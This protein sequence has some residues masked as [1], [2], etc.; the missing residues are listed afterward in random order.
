MMT[1]I[2]IASYSQDKT[3]EL[4]QESDETFY[5]YDLGENGIL[6]SIPKIYEHNSVV[7][8]YQVKSQKIMKYSNQLEKEW[9]VNV[10]NPKGTD[11]SNLTYSKEG[12]NV[13]IENM[14]FSQYSESVYQL[15]N[16]KD[17]EIKNKKEFD[18]N[19][20]EKIRKNLM[21]SFCDNENFYML[22]SLN[23]KQYEKSKIDEKLVLTIFKGESMIMEKHVLNLPKIEN[24]ENTT[25][26]DYLDHHDGEIYLQSKEIFSDVIKYTIL[27]INSNGEILNTTTITVSMNGN[28]IAPAM[29]VK[30]RTNHF[31]YSNTYF[32][33]NL[34][35]YSDVI[36]TKDY[37][38]LIVYGLYGDHIYRETERK[39]EGYFLKK[40]NLK[41]ELIFD[42]MT[43]ISPKLK[44]DE[45]F[46]FKDLAYNRYLILD[47]LI[48]KTIQL[49]FVT[50][51]DHVFTNNFSEK[52]E[53]LSESDI[54]FYKIIHVLDLNYAYQPH[55][56][57]KVFDI[58]NTFAPSKNDVS[59]KYIKT[60][61]KMKKEKSMIF[62]FFPSSQSEIIVINNPEYKRKDKV[63]K[64]LLFKKQIK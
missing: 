22:S 9:D 42:N 49:Q 31:Y 21:E 58:E 10:E 56:K 5:V 41:G 39:I 43:K 37:S 18:Y 45:G 44:K 30:N 60:L 61:P 46:Y 4:F 53:L 35:A 26:W 12:S 54:D 27:T 7:S 50:Y 11:K 14:K 51:K 33:P 25:F 32:R 62:S 63:I 29:C 3:V 20:M 13:Y 40:Y 64:M 59:I 17:G 8:I 19:E 24:A 55:I 47:E 38:S 16:I 34:G 57:R 1:L 36:F 6:V 48:D 52:G 28:H 2:S 15:I 23:G